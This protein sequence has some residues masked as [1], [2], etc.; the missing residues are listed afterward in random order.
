MQKYQCMRNEKLIR[1]RIAVLGIAVILAGCSSTK[2]P[3]PNPKLP[4]FVFKTSSSVQKKE[5]TNHYQFANYVR[6]ASARYGVDEALVRSIIEVESSFNPTAVSKSNA[7][8]LMQIKSSTSG[9]DVYRLKGQHGEPSRSELMDPKTNIDIGTAYLSILRNQHLSG[10]R[11]PKTMRYAMI[12][13]YANGAGALLRTFD[14]DRST[15][16]AKIN[17]MSPEDF[18]QHVQTKHP[19]PQAPRYLFKVNSVYTASR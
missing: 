9:K 7:I 8:G 11:D 6:P 15:A 13:A 1:I 19:A 5:E 18:Y 10:I 3:K 16:I 14:K 4:N 2:A 17:R 12:V